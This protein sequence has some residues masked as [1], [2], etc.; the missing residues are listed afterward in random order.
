M[1]LLHR[2][3]IECLLAPRTSLQVLGRIGNGLAGLRWCAQTNATL[4][5]WGVRAR[6]M[7]RNADLEDLSLAREAHPEVNSATA[8]QA[9]HDNSAG[10]IGDGA[11]SDVAEP[12]TEVAPAAAEPGMKADDP[13]AIF[14][15]ASA[16]PP[17]GNLCQWPE[18]SEVQPSAA[19]VGTCPM[20]CIGNQKSEVRLLQEEVE[21][22]GNEL[23]A[24]EAEL[25]AELMAEDSES[26][27]GEPEEE[28]KK[29]VD[30]VE[31]SAI[32]V[33]PQGCPEIGITCNMEVQAS[34]A[35]QLLPHSW[36]WDQRLDDA[37]VKLS[38]V[39]MKLQGCDDW[40]AEMGV[41]WR[42]IQDPE[43]AQGAMAAAIGLTES[44]RNAANSLDELTCERKQLIS[45]LDLR[46]RHLQKVGSQVLD[47]YLERGVLP[48]DDTEVRRLETPAVQ[49]EVQPASPITAFSQE[50]QVWLTT[51]MACGDSEAADLLDRIL[52]TLQQILAQGGSQ[53]SFEAAGLLEVYRGGQP[54]DSSIQEAI[55]LPDACHLRQAMRYLYQ[56]APCL[57]WLCSAASSSTRHG[58][59]EA[60]ATKPPADSFLHFR[61]APV[62]NDT[63]NLHLEPH[64]VAPVDFA[65]MD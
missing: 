22:L 21:D 40:S 52:S 6:A 20:S 25:Q 13:L 29:E 43:K 15:V 64:S 5:S 4:G 51:L 32:N 2:P 30:K 41:L 61:A 28:P 62:S 23:G 46:L 63:P 55:H 26:D 11:C 34:E 60:T 44:S 31:D 58:E 57:A 36:L 9:D 38:A 14:R 37:R 24:L 39:I 10:E 59:R 50:A 8:I 1:I 12:E 19:D 47:E 33:L 56:N 45:E 49:F 7:L 48:S 65:E 35:S 3:S 54:I 27:T 16:A 42:K 17:T 53:E 18:C